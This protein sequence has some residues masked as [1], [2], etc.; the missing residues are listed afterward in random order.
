[1]ARRRSTGR[2]GS[3][4]RLSDTVGRDAGHK[5][6]ASLGVYDTRNLPP[7]LTLIVPGGPL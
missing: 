3:A 4:L 5:N 1:M 2:Q 6:S 7:M